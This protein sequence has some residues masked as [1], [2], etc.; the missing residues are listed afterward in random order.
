MKPGRT[1]GFI[2]VFVGGLLVTLT[3]VYANHVIAGGVIYAPTSDLSETSVQCQFFGV[4]SSVSLA[5]FV[6]PTTI[7]C[8]VL[9]RGESMLFRL[10]TDGTELEPFTVVRLNPDPSQPFPRRITI[11]GKMR[12]QLVVGV[13]TD[14]QLFTEIAPSFEAVGMDVADPG[15]GQDSFTLTIHFDKSLDIGRLLSDALGTPLVEC[16]GSTCALTVAGTVIDGDNTCHT[17]AGD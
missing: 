12:S 13:G 7:Q 14:L 8:T 2:A 4:K 5:A 11:T 15:V 10:S 17:A 9:H 6:V 16:N 1:L 3:S